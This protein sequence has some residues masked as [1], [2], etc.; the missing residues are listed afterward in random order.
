MKNIV[1]IKD[2]PETAWEHGPHWGGADKDLTPAMQPRRG[3]IGMVATRVA[4]GA[5]ACPFHTHQREDEIFFVL[6][7]RGIF[8]YGEEIAEIGPGDAISCPAGAGVAHQLANPFDE[9]LVYLSIGKDDA[10]EVCTY[11][12]TGK[13]MVRSLGLVG[14]LQAR[15][16]MDGEPPLPGIF[17]LY[18]D[19]VK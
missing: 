6:S 17:G 3:R 19:R 2:A 7:G 4:P 18:K 12:D 8:R 11:P 5:S 9:E 1:N 13:I 16:Y 10:D 15:D 14:P